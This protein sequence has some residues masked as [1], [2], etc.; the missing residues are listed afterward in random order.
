MIK[1]QLILTVY[2][3]HQIGTIIHLNIYHFFICCQNFS[4]QP[5][6]LFVDLNAINSDILKMSE[7]E[8]VRV[9]R[10]SHQRCSITKGV[11]RNFAKFTG[12]HLCQSFFFNKVAGLGLQLY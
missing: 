5:N 10:S 8:I 1:Q 9:S 4:N 6:V 3:P 11:L 2:F 7:K 12:K